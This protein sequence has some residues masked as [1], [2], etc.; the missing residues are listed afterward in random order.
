MLFVELIR[1]DDTDEKVSDALFNRSNARIGGCFFCWIQYC[2]CRR[3]VC[4]FDKCIMGVAFFI[5]N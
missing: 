4:M 3:L 1:V 2:C 5:L